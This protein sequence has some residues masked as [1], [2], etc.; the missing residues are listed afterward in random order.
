MRDRERARDDIDRREVAWRSQLGVSTGGG[1][2][3]PARPARPARRD[4][5]GAVAPRLHALPKRE[6]WAVNRKRVYR[7]FR[8]EGLSLMRK[9]PRRRKAATVRPVRPTTVTANQSWAMDFMHDVLASGQKI[10]RCGVAMPCVGRECFTQHWL[11]SRTEP[12]LVLR[13]GRT[14]TTLRVRTKS[15][16]N[17]P[18]ATYAATAAGGHFTPSLFD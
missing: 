7:L 9:R 13:E 10:P 15:L 5:L 16:A 3:R 18:P 11:A 14:T 8:E 1:R 17:A 12:Q 4:A 2:A 6:G